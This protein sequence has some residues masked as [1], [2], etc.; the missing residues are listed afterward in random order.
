MTVD[1][2]PESP[3]YQKGV[4]GAGKDVVHQIRYDA[5]KSA[6]VLGMTYRSIAET[7]EDTVA[8]WEARGW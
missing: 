6:R 3:K 8:D 5:S 4:H 2:A 1:A 7:M